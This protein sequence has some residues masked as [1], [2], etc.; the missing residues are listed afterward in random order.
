[1]SFSVEVKT[2]YGNSYP[3]D[4]TDGKQ[5]GGVFRKTTNTLS[6][7]GSTPSMTLTGLSALS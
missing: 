4:R 3:P 2:V 7:A 6:F 5:Y 1:M